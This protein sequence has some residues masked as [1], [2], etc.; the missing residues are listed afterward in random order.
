MSDAELQQLS[1]FAMFLISQAIFKVWTRIEKST[2]KPKA[3][4]I[5]FSFAGFEVVSLDIDSE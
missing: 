5:Q 1:F 4:E 3:D 2:E